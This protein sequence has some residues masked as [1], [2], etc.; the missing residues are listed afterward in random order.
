[1]RLWFWGW[2]VA[3]VAIAVVSAAVRDRSSAP[4]A[5]GAAVAAALE[6]ARIDP[7]M[8]W[9]AFAGVS[10]AVFIAVNRRRYRARHS[11]R[12]VGRHGART[13]GDDR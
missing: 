8:Q 10:I 11:V 9:L 12:A 13:A 6:A 3:A 5:V 7:G 2:L 4:F 1:V